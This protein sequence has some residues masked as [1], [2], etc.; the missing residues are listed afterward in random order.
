MS[1]ERQTV[2]IE[3]MSNCYYPQVWITGDYF[4][5]CDR[6]NC[7]K[8]KAVNSVD[9]DGQPIR[10]HAYVT[11]PVSS[12]ENDK[13]K[14]REWKRLFSVDV[15]IDMLKLETDPDAYDIVKDWVFVIYIEDDDEE[16]K[17]VLLIDRPHSFEKLVFI[18]EEA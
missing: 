10:L 11:H 1:K 18:K 15:L 13:I 3:I 14:I 6:I 16:E 4:Y 2:K 8:G 17:E 7:A 5:D 9:L 12:K